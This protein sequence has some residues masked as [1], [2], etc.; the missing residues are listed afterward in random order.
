LQGASL[1][2]AQLQGASLDGA[3][4]QGASLDGAQLQGA[5]LANVFVWRMVPPE[6]Q[7]V[8]HS[9]IV[10]PI[11]DAKYFD[12]QCKENKEN[13]CDWTRSYYE[14]LK[15]KIEAAPPGKLREAALERIKPLGAEPFTVEEKAAETWL[16]LAKASEAAAKDYPAWLAESLI[17]TGCDGR[18]APYVIRGLLRQLDDRFSLDDPQEAAVVNAF[19]DPGCE[20]ARGLSDDDKA[21]L[22]RLA[23]PPA[24]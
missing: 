17:R 7:S 6:P 9:R 12:S 20:G 19:L 14:A 5:S 10:S 15:A 11:R 4:L 24:K 16:A 1:D 22:R 18:G 8:E 3:Q 23:S 21:E 13:K 2:G